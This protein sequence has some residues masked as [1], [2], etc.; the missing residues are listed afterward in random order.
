MAIEPFIK[1]SDVAKS[2]EFYTK[3][4]DF[5]VLQPPDPDRNSFMSKY[6]LIARELSLV[7]LSAHEN[8]GNFGNVIYVRVNDIDSLFNSYVANGLILD[9]SSEYP[10]LL[11]PPTEQSWGMKEFCIRDPDGNKITFGHQINS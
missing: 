11:I 6:A 7:H 3:I 9:N 4:L 10:S 2:I 8:D 5:V 1:C